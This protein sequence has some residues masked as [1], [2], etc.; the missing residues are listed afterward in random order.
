VRKATDLEANPEEK[1]KVHKE[2]AAVKSS[3][4]MKEWHKGHT[5]ATGCCG[6]KK[7]LT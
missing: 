5:L 1:E 6:K 4:A 3:R 7:E 2:E